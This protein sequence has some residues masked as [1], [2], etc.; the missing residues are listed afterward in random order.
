M[1]KYILSLITT[2][3]TIGVMAQPNGAETVEIM[4]LKT[5]DGKVVRYEVKNI[6]QLSFGS[7]FHSFGGYITATGKYFKD[8][9]FGGTAKLYV[10]NSAEGYD[11]SLSDSIWGEAEFENVTMGRGSL[12]G[13]G[14]ITVSQQYG[15]GTYEATISGPMT[16]PVITIPSLMQGGTTLTFY[17]GD[18]PQSLLVK[19]SHQGSVSVMV[20]SSFGPYINNNVT[21]TITAN[22]DGTINIVVPEYTLENT[23][24]GNLTLGT[25]TISNVAYNSEKGSF[26]RDY[27]SDG[28]SFHF[29]AT[30]GSTEL[31]SDYAFTK[32]GNIEVRKTETGLTIVN[33]FQPGNMP[34][35]IVSN[36]EKATQTPKH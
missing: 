5:A 15:G 25:Y 18:V 27:T 16:T 17:M 10:W 12:S 21:Y 11:V 26:Y 6:E 13:I 28:L 9:Y 34:F 7:L 8:S 35:P 2:L 32:L 1:K 3:F 23:Q 33:Y 22:A 29:K 19:G 14:S 36:F 30:G 31:D 20:G 24:I 4:K